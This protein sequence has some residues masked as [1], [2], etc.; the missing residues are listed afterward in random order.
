MWRMQAGWR[1]QSFWPQEAD[2]GSQGPTSLHPPATLQILEAV[3]PPAASSADNKALARYHSLA[4]P[5]PLRPMP[6]P[7][8][9]RAALDREFP[10]MALLK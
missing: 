5:L 9:L 6:D 4:S 10:W 3:P 8:R 2:L 7:D 1:S